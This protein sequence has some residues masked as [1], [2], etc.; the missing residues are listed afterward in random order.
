MSTIR[1]L[2]ACAVLTEDAK[3]HILREGPLEAIMLFPYREGWDSFG[4][5]SAKAIVANVLKMPMPPVPS[6][7]SGES[8]EDKKAWRHGWRDA[9]QAFSD[10]RASMDSRENM[11]VPVFTEETG[12]L[13]W[14]KRK[15]AK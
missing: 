9:Y 6:P 5:W 10:G 1:H 4:T 13:I 12:L 15:P 8:E 3:R 14:K 7:D 2:P 11:P